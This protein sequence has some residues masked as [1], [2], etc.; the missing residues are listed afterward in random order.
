M[1]R[2]AKVFD[3]YTS[4][5]GNIGPCVGETEQ[6]KPPWTIIRGDEMPPMMFQIR[7]HDGRISSYTYGDLHEVHSPNAGT[8]E[9]YLYS[10]RKLRITIE[11]RHLRE[12]ANLMGN[13]VV[14]VIE[15]A[16]PRDVDVPE[17]SPEIT[18][19]SVLTLDEQTA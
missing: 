8:V 16:D 7:F 9:L 10:L 6:H 17:S 3:R 13:A 12:L 18:R 14:R 11:G 1:T 19:I 2:V 5:T 4:P 15:E